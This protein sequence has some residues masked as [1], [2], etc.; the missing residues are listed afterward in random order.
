MLR[1]ASPKSSPDVYKV[2][3]QSSMKCGTSGTD[4]ALAE[5]S[6]NRMTRLL[7]SKV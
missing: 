1:R 7:P 2:L 3:G 4:N 6:A 5:R